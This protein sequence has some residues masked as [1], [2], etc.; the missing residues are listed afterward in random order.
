MRTIQHESTRR[1]IADPEESHMLTTNPPTNPPTSE[2]QLHRMF[3]PIPHIPISMP[4]NIDIPQFDPL[5]DL[6]IADMDMYMDTHHSEETEPELP[7][8][9]IN[10]YR[11][12]RVIQ[13]KNEWCQIVTG[14]K[15]NILKDL[16]TYLQKDEVNRN[17]IY[18][19]QDQIVLTLFKLRQNHD[20]QVIAG[21]IGLNP[22]TV[23]GYFHKWINIMYHKLRFLV[24]MQD[25]D[26]IF[27]TIPNHFRSE[28]PK[29]TS[30]IDC[31][32]IRCE[33]PEK[34]RLKA[35]LY[36]NY[37]KHSTIKILISCSP[38]G[39]INFVS[40]AW[41][42][43]ASDKTIVLESGFDKHTFHNPGDQILADRGFDLK[44]EFNIGS[45]STLIVPA[46][47]RMRKQLTS[48]D[49]EETR[50]IAHVRIHIERVICELRNRY[51][52]L[53]EGGGTMPLTLVKA[54]NGICTIDQIVTTCAA[55]CNLRLGVIQKH[56]NK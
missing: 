30:I 1:N 40:K 42:G 11:Y 37:K 23:S 25:R 19:L 24:K 21:T 27:D 35:Q 7:S 29:I 18:S 10:P 6:P 28:F 34:L 44:E 38:T 8:S 52:I 46:F 4:L 22:K 15:P 54:R 26:H 47:K 48:L 39:S 56:L 41:G 32:E 2:S 51:K 31:F 5:I 17:Q 33:S 12:E 50:K 36:S 45:R 43:R 14:L 16:V 9:Q 20:F 49:V 3:S 55:L 13:N 53:G